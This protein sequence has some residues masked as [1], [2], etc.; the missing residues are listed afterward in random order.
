[1]KKNLFLF[2]ALTMLTTPM[3]FAQD[4]KFRLG[5]KTSPNVSW[6]NT[7]S[8]HLTAGDKSFRFGYGL[9]FDIFFSE[10]YA[11][12][13]GFNVNK[14]GGTMSYFQSYIGTEP[15]PLPGGNPLTNMNQIGLLSRDISL[16]YVQ[17]PLTFKM[18]TPEIGYMTYW[19]QFGLGLNY[20][21]K[22]LSTD[23]IVFQL[24][25][26]KNTFDWEPSKRE[27][28]TFEKND[29]KNDINLFGANLIFAAGIEY[30]LAGKTSILASVSYHNGFT[31]ALK[32]EA[33]QMDNVTKGPS[34]N[35]DATQTAK[36]FELSARPNYIELNIGVLF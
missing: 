23:E 10:N 32:G 17:V 7:D 6:F 21:S 14:T 22:A 9:N 2:I 4:S 33:V 28:E 24:Y 20:N 25:Q 31:D 30:N 13:T 3:L 12:G 5:F 35:N 36:T 8:P 1:M 19:G 15:A 16:Q 26:D 34:I 27:S 29:I 11:I 18:K